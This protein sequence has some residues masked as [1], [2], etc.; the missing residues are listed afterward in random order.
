MDL[1]QVEYALAVID[2]GGF[3]RAAEALHVAQPSLSQSVRKLESE[4]GAPLFH[5]VRR[6]VV[7]SAAGEA[8]V[9]PARQLVR[10]RDAVRTSVAAVAALAAG[11]LDLVSLPT[12]APEPLAELV[13]AFRRGHPGVSVRVTAPD[14]RHEL[15]AMVADGRS[16]VGLG[17]LPGSRRDLVAVRLA[18]QELVAVLPPGTAPPGRGRLPVAALAHHPL[19]TTPRHTSTREWLERALESVR[20]APD[21]A[22][23]TEHREA[24]VPLVLEGAGAA[25]LPEN[26]AR[27][28]ADAGAVVVPLT[29]RLT[30]TI[31]LLHRPDESS[32]AAHEFVRIAREVVEPA[33]AGR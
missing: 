31:G 22:V 25:V 28:A 9:G 11:T 2:H 4:L 17:E 27:R 10:S 12:L 8:F 14:D 26:L 15:E 21:V 32:P 1:R 5:R 18:D 24:V 29:P 3:T 20:V 7:L 23:E 30:R 19:V 33:T 16:E 6:R 13:G